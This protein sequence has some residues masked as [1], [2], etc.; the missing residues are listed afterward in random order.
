[1]RAQRLGTRRITRLDHGRAIGLIASGSSSRR[2][3]RLTPLFSE[4]NYE[5]ITGALEVQYLPKFESLI[6]LPRA[7]VIFPKKPVN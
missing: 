4:T 6:S 1:M 5:C 7:S 3:I 2:V